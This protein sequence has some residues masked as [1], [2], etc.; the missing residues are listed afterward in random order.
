[1]KLPDIEI[2]KRLF[3]GKG[4]PTNVLGV[5]P[6]E[7]RGS[8]YIEGPTV[9][10]D[11]SLFKP[12]PQ[13]MAT[14][15]CGPT[16]N[17]DVVK[18]GTIP[19]LSL[20]VQTYARIKAF[21]KV[22]TLL[23]VRLIKSDVIYTNVLMANTKNFVI[24]HPLKEGKKLVHGCLEGPEHSVYVRGRL[25]NNNI[26]ELPDYWIN[27]VDETTITVSLT[28]I[29]AEQSLFVAKIKDNKIVVGNYMTEFGELPIDCF[30]HVFAERK[31]V[32][33]LETEI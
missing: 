33:K 17:P 9:T 27:L 20:F 28:A 6:T 30:Y 24:D 32:N 31:D 25:R 21:L 10:G 4:N 7:V 14:V 15:M 13:E 11:P 5:G 18:V 1:M 8:G 12:A 22:D 29:G 19:F 16:K 23:S 26:I 3:C 2:G